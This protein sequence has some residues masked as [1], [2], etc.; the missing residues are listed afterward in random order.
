MGTKEPCV[1]ASIDK[2]MLQV[3][4]WHYNFVKNEWTTIDYFGGLK[5]FY[6]QLLKGDRSDGI[7]GVAG[8]G[9][10]KAARMLEGCETEQE[11]FD[12]CRQAYNDDELMFMYGSCLWIQRE[13]GKVWDYTHLL[14]G[15]NQSDYEAAEP[16]GSTTPRPEEINLSL[17]LITP[18]KDGYLV[19][20]H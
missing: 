12:I 11:M 7:P 15:E 18:D 6:E 9:E 14:T 16:S 13:E 17:D 3:P 20:G 2:D 5:R 10:K 8:L 19:H 4:G 1:I